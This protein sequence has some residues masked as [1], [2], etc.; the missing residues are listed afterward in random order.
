MIKIKLNE[1]I[2]VDGVLLSEIS[3]REPKVKDIMAISK[4][5]GSDYEKEVRLVANLSEQSTE[6]IME[7][8]F[9]D[10]AKIQKVIRDFLA[11][12]E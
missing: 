7:I 8:S 12:V 2:K 5:N 3:L 1:P 6:S 10:Y 11:P 9:K 4:G